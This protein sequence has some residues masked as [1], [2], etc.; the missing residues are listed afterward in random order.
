MGNCTSNSY[1]PKAINLCYERK[2][3]EVKL[4]LRSNA[5]E[6]KKIESLMYKY[7][8]V[9]TCLHEACSYRAPVHVIQAMIQIGGPELLKEGTS[10]ALHNACTRRFGAPAEVV[11]LLVDAGGK[12]LVMQKDHRGR[13]AL[14]NVCRS[15]ASIEIVEFLVHA[16]GKDLVV[17]RDNHGRTALHNA[18]RYLA[19]A[20]VVEILIATGGQELVMQSANHGESALHEVRFHKVQKYSETL[21]IIR[22]LVTVGGRELVMQEHKYG[23]TAL[24]RICMHITSK[25]PPSETSEAL[26]ML[27]WLRERKVLLK[28]DIQKYGLLAESCFTQDFQ[29]EIFRYLVDWNPGALKESEHRSILHKILALG[30]YGTKGIIDGNPQALQTFRMILQATMKHFTDEIGL[31]VQQYDDQDSSCATSVLEKA[32]SMFGKETTWNVIK[33][34]L[35]DASI[36]G[37]IHETNARTNLY[38]FMVVAAGDNSDLSIVYHLFRTSPIVLDHRPPRYK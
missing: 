37:S 22:A 19:S 27:T 36:K 15:G 30:N 12:D 18:C 10:N 38:P 7:N 16:G 24:R 32:Y 2:W 25:T 14:H 13:T 33:E 26:D 28:Q 9:W 20:E 5:T 4:F 34:C 1:P 11:E 31:L 6:K 29:E 17:Q 21:D 8:D 3:N 35:D 23:T